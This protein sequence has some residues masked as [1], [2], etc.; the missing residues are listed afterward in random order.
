MKILIRQII[1]SKINF[2]FMKATVLL[3]LCNLFTLHATVFSQTKVT[4][5]GENIPL[6]SALV[7]IE[8]VA[9]V[10]FVYR[11]ETISDYKVNFD[12]QN[13]SIEETLNVLLRG[14]GN[15]YRTLD[16]NLIVIAPMEFVQG[17][18]I[19][20]AITDHAGV[21][22]PGVNVMVKGTATGAISDFNGK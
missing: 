3:I 22:I 19:T 12:L 9:Q 8:K 2:K 18:V 11:D 6:K 20:G 15:T 14:T 4:M 10:K 1:Y 13:S 5:K 17:I 7:Q 16:N 21:S